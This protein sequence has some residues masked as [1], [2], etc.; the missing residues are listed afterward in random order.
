[1]LLEFL[2][3]LQEQQRFNA[4]QKAHG[5][6]AESHEFARTRVGP[7]YSRTGCCSWCCFFVTGPCHKPEDGGW[8]IL[9]LVRIHSEWNGFSSRFIVNYPVCTGILIGQKKWI[10][11]LKTQ[12][13]IHEGGITVIRISLLEP[14]WGKIN[15]PLYRVGCCRHLCRGWFWVRAAVW[16][17]ARSGRQTVTGCL[18][19]CTDG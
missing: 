12:D 1:M 8:I 5:N 9:W 14:V 15:Y 11:K 10:K 18:E 17:A 3:G 6:Q 7:Q 16:I 2:M 4:S 13:N 19:D